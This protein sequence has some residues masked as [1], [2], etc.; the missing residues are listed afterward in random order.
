[1]KIKIQSCFAGGQ[2]FYF[3]A[4]VCGGLLVRH[5]GSGWNRRIA[6]EMLDLL[7]VHGFDRSSVR[8]VHV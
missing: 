3:R 6:T 5:D 2:K 4:L 1:V 7:E 8:F